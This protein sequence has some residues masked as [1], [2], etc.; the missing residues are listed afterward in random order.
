MFRR[1]LAAAITLALAAF[2][3]V[4]G[5]P[6]LFG[7]QRAPGVAHAVSFRG[8]AFVVA[9]ALIVLFTL[10]ALISPRLRRFAAGLALVLVVFAAVTFGVLVLRGLG[11]PSMPTK[12]PEEVTV[13]NWNT[14][15][16]SP[17]A[18]VIADLVVQQEA[19]VVSLP[20]TSGAAAQ[21]VAD[22]LADQGRPM[23]VLTL[24]FDEVSKARTTSLLVSTRL[25]EYVRD[26]SRGTTPGLPSIV[27]VPTDGTG[28][29]IIAA[30]PIAPVPGEFSKWRDGLDWLS[31]VCD[32]PNVILAGDLNATLDHFAGLEV[33]EAQ[34]G[35][36]HDAAKAT[37]NAAVGTWP[38]LLPQLLATPIDHVMATDGW[39][40]MGFRVIGSL[41]GVGSDHRPVVA[42]LRALR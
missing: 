41:D 27:A 34:L 29:T 4:I 28:P 8:V 1:I 26:D 36:C 11:N 38:T 9:L 19:D 39:K 3:L 15:G 23:Q 7:L 10:I 22:L 30:H 25:G 12:A 33:G 37:G 20:E 32:A 2:L 35:A 42:Q 31:A 16:D 14:L 13:L 24:A 6:Q 40:V 5:W 18:Q 21:A 17:G